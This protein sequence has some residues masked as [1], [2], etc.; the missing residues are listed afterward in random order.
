MEWVVGKT[1]EIHGM[2]WTGYKRWMVDI[3]WKQ[4]GQ[5]TRDGWLI[6]NGY[7]MDRTQE[8]H[9]HGMDKL[10]ERGRKIQNL[11]GMH[12]IIINRGVYFSEFTPPLLGGI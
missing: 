8:M 3:E 6:W 11:Y 5:D 9:G 12:I 7:R 4:D 10:I 1:Q 2:G